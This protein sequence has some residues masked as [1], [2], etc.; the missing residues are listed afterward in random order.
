MFETY[1]QTNHPIPIHSRQIA[2]AFDSTI[3]CSSLTNPI[4]INVIP[5]RPMATLSMFLRPT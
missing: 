4:I 1:F 5:K 3:N 2:T